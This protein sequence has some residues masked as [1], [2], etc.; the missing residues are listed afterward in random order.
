MSIAALFTT[1]RKWNQPRCPPT[2]EERMEIQSLYGIS[3]GC[4]NGIM[5]FVGRWMDGLGCN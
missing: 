3:F 1:A 2:H 5:T 4:K